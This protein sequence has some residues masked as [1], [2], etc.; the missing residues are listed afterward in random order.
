MKS[1]NLKLALLLIS[2][3]ILGS[4]KVAADS[5]GAI[6]GE[7]VDYVNKN[8]EK[9]LVPISENETSLIDWELK[10]IRVRVQSQLGIKIPWVTSFQVVP[11]VEFIFER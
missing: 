3:S 2:F 6:Q 10:R 9:A 1:L 7:V 4:L 5:G 11:E 8:I